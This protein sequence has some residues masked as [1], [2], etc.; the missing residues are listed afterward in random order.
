MKRLFVELFSCV[1]RIANVLR[2]GTAD[3]TLS[4]SAHDQGLRLERIIDAIFR[5]WEGPGHCRR[6]W[7][8]EVARSRAIVERAKGRE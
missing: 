6:W 2:G 7:L 5:L 3:M 1:S 8:E 4:A